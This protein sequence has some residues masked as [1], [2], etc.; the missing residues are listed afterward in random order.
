MRAE[1]RNGSGRKNLLSTG[2]ARVISSWSAC[3]LS[4]K[5]RR[6]PSGEP[7]SCCWPWLAA[8]VAPGGVD[9]S[10]LS[11]EGCAPATAH[12]MCDSGQPGQGRDCAPGLQQLGIPT[13]RLWAGTRKHDGPPAGNTSERCGIMPASA[14]AWGNVRRKDACST[15]APVCTRA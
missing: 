4:A 3:R 13:S 7:R 14:C 5:R 11:G 10:R 9:G 6:R 2:G 15:A 12:P 8:S 1:A